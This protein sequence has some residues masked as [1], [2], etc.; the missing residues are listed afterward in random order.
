[1]G[2]VYVA[3]S[4]I[5][6]QGVF[7]A[8]TL[9]PGEPVLALDDSRVVTPDDPLRPDDG[10]HRRFCDFVMGD[11]V[12]LMQPPERYINHSCS[13]NVF[14]KTFDGVRYLFALKMIYMTEEL[15]LDYC[16]NSRGDTLWLCNCGSP[17]CRHTVHSDFFRLPY[18]LQ[19][20]YL[21]LLDAWFVQEYQDPINALL[22]KA[23]R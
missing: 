5:H 16:I 20:E 10:E 4:R 13:P 3:E 12:V 19:L 8:V 6:G 9:K 2:K 23:L 15:T 7:A 14:V 22:R 1:M 11:R 21:P 18:L 17:R